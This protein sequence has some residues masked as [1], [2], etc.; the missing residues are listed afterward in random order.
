[1][2]RICSK[3]NKKIKYAARLKQKSFRKQEACFLIEGKKMLEEALKHPKLLR[4]IFIEAELAPGYMELYQQHP[5]WECYV[6]DKRLMKHI[7]DTETPPGIVAVCQIPSWPREEFLSKNA[8]LLYL[9]R[10]A[11]PGNLGTIIR[12]GWALGVD[13][14]LLSPESVDPFSPKVVRASMGGIFNIPLLLDFSVDELKSLKQNAYTFFCASLQARLEVFSLDFTGPSLLAIGSESQGVR[15][16][17]EEI[18]DINC[19]IPIKPGVDSLNAAV[20]CAIIIN[21]AWKQ[22]Q[23]FFLS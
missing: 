8:F 18:C 9:D 17:I 14:I 6:V 13:G 11:D 22:R 3:D 23:G 2:L 20:A 15:P 19:K 7:S 5:E 16:V 21:E 10:I 12:S 1:M 4:Q